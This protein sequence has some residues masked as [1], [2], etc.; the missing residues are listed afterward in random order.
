MPA[1][2]KAAI[3]KSVPK[4]PVKQTGSSNKKRDKMIQAKPPGL[5]KSSSGK[6]YTETRRNRSDKG[7]LLG[8][9]DTSVIKEID[10]LKRE[11]KKMA[12]KLHPDAGGTKEQFQELQRQYEK[13]LKDLLAGSDLSKDQ[14]VN[15]MAIDKQLRDIIDQLIVLPNI[16]VEL[17]G[18]WIWV[19]GDTY[20]IKDVLK[21]AG[22][23]FIK[24]AGKPY[25]VYKGVESSGRGNLSVE[26]I[27]SKY[28][29]HKMDLKPTK[30]I[31]YGRIVNK[32]KLKMS[33]RK[34][35]RS[36]DKRPI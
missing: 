12:K 22:L 19:S 34:L 29:S 13:L 25:W 11:Y 15:E 1:K 26:E 2:K 8:L 17:I 5:R 16:D 21:S 35:L 10:D 23:T 31:G 3:K 27:R 6:V 4:K 36:L 18:K 20:P 28:G 32:T 14:Q 9:F 7:R 33:F 30:K 24:K